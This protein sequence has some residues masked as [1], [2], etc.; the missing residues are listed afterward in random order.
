MRQA[1]INNLN[2]KYINNTLAQNL[3]PAFANPNNLFPMPFDNNNLPP[4]T[5]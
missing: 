3:S 4:P 5:A 1:S 2:A